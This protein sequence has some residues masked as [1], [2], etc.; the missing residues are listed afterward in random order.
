MKF[1]NIHTQSWPQKGW[2]IQWS[3]IDIDAT[4]SIEIYRSEAQEGPWTLLDTLAHDVVSY[5][6]CINQP[7]SIGVFKDVYY[8]ILV[9]NAA[10]EIVLESTPQSTQ[11]RNSRIINEIIRQHNLT[12]YGIN[13]HPGFFSQD[14][15][16]FKKQTL[17]EEYQLSRGPNGEKMLAF[18]EVDDNTGYAAGYANPIKF[19]GRWIDGVQVQKRQ[20]ATGNREEFN[21]QLWTSNFPILYPG[22]IIVEKSSG[23]VY[24]VRSISRREPNGSLVS[25]TAM[26]SQMMPNTIEAKTLRYDC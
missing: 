4:H 18:S 24:E 6:D 10:D 1:E 11:T 25:Q 13:G 16:C 15:A 23:R 8:R 7:N 26:C 21:R 2:K 14:F 17:G 19:R 3:I 12:L 22:D 9:K 5:I 20:R